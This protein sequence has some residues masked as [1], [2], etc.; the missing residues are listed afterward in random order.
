MLPIEKFSEFPVLR[1]LESF[2]LPATETQLTNLSKY[3]EIV[4]LCILPVWRDLGRELALET[5][6]NQRLKGHL[7]AFTCA[8][9]IL[10]DQIPPCSGSLELFAHVFTNQGE[11]SPFSLAKC[12][13]S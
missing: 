13:K 6:W 5:Q 3:R 4:G 11:K 9:F 7:V 12:E 2:R 1:V 8:G 10:S